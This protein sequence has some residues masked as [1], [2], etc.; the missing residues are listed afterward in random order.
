MTARTV[1]SIPADAR[2]RHFDQLSPRA[3]EVFLDLVA[4]AGRPVH[5]PVQEDLEAG[6]VIVFTD[7]YLVGSEE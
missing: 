5:V 1:G 6:E 4:P 2:V 3:S 7:Y